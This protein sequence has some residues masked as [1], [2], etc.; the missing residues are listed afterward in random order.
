MKPHIAILNQSAL[1]TGKPQ[2]KAPFI[3]FLLLVCTSLS[4]CAMAQFLTGRLGRAQFMC[5]GF[6]GRVQSLQGAERTTAPHNYRQ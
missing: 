6:G 5:G 2:T 1:H 4:L 3:F